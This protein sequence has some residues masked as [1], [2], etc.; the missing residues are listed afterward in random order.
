M[1]LFSKFKFWRL[2]TLLL[3]TSPEKISKLQY[4]RI[5]CVLRQN[6]I[7]NQKRKQTRLD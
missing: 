4:I 7:K 6:E 3:R 2:R 1:Y 5:N